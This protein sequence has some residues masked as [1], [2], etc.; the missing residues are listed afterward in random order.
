L[1][2]VEVVVVVELLLEMLVV[3]ADSYHSQ[4]AHFW[5]IRRRI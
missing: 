2:L 5:S 3:A 1:I 4:G